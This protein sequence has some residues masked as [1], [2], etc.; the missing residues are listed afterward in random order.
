M[1][2]GVP[3]SWATTV[4]AGSTARARR[5]CSVVAVRL[6]TGAGEVGHEPERRR[7]D[8]LELIAQRVRFVA[9][10]PPTRLTTITALASLISGIA[11]ATMPTGEVSITTRS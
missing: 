2:P 4:T 7:I 11:S 9:G 6:V 8:A 1:P 10:D 3:T 5:G